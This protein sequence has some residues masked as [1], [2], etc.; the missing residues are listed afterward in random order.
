MRK[1]LA[2]MGY[3]FASSDG[4]TYAY[5]RSS[6]SAKDAELSREDRNLRG[7]IW[8]FFTNS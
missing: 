7:Q 4:K 5:E 1:T 8:R 6:I 3:V 2:N